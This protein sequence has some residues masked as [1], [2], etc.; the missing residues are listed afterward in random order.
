MA[1]SWPKERRLI[2]KKTP[3]IDGPDKATGHA[4]Y[5]F[6]I[7]RPGMLHGKIF[8]STYAR[9]KIKGIDN[10]ASQAVAGLKGVLVS[11]PCRTRVFVLWSA[12]DGLRCAPV[13]ER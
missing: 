4:K 1:Y 3:R 6:D 2:G 10:A 11:G 9:W 5:S 8:R 12:A 7:N 13:V